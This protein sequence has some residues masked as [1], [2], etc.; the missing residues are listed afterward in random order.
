MVGVH[1]AVILLWE[2]FAIR[3]RSQPSFHPPR[4][5]EVKALRSVKWGRCLRIEAVYVVWLSRCWLKGLGPVP[6]SELT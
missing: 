2:V 3:P 4:E 1:P 5:T 6:G